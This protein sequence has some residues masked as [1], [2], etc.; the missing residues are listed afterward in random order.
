MRRKAVRITLLSLL[1][2]SSL[3]FIF[4]SDI[5]PGISTQRPSR[6]ILWIIQEVIKHIKEDYVE[7]PDPSLTM[8][9]AFK[10]LVNSLDEFS[11]YLTKESVSKRQI[12]ENG[13]LYDIG[14][15]LYKKYR[16]FS[17]VIGRTTSI[18]K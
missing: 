10:G 13:I 9:G 11:S 16:S 3:V 12:L 7:E 1:A 17:V 5:L 2:L 14:I 6:G 8:E 4:E 15:I 18:F